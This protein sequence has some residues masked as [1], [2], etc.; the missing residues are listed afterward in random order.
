MTC[1][2]PSHLSPQL[3]SKNKESNMKKIETRRASR[4]LIALSLITLVLSPTNA[5]AKTRVDGG[6][7]TNLDPA[8]AKIHL[9]LSTF[10]A[11]P[12]GVGL[13]VL[14][15]L[16]GVS[17]GKTKDFCDTDHQLWISNTPGA[18]FAPSADIVL[19]VTGTVAGTACGTDKCSIFVTFDHTNASDRSEDQLIPISFAAGVSTP[20]KPKDAIVATINGKELSTS[21][22]GTLAYRTPVTITATSKS[23]GAITFGSSTPDCT[24]VNGVLTALKA[25]GACDITVSTPDALE[26]QKTTAHYPFL[27]TQGVQKIAPF[28]LKLAKGASLKLPATTNFAEKIVYTTSSS[29]ICNVKGSTLKALKKGACVVTASAAGQDGLWAATKE[30]R[31][32]KIS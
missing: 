17:A 1:L 25:T 23:G 27:L 31:V 29:K 9:A 13:Y 10:P 14:Q 22:P 12:A 20:T 2:F 4:V 6:P 24:V 8:G 18:S 21:I 15:C 16:N 26:Y 5:F 19:T 30:K 11:T 7:L 32:V 3:Q 28:K